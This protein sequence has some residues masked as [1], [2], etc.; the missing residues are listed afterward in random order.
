MKANLT[1]DIDFR[2]YLLI[3][4]FL[5]TFVEAKY[6]SRACPP[7]LPPTPISSLPF[8]R[9]C[10]SWNAIFYCLKSSIPSTFGF[11]DGFMLID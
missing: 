2:K 5:I 7:S 6:K 9:S 10:F 11:Q 3:Y 1:A 4:L 8:S